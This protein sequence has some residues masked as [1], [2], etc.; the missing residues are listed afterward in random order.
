MGLGDFKL[1][2][3]MDGYLNATLQYTV[4]Y[5]KTLNELIRF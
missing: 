1:V 5:C 3:H 2:V 4:T